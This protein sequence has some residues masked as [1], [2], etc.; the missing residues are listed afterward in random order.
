MRKN[1][2]TK[3]ISDTRYPV[4][5]TMFNNKV[6][7]FKKKVLIEIKSKILSNYLSQLSTIATKNGHSL[8][9]FTATV[10]QSNK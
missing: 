9:K 7:E 2:W 6:K 4:N 3:M 10:K 8:W 1:T 5:K